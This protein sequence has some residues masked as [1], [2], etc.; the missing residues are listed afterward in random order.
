MSNFISTFATAMTKFDEGTEAFDAYAS[1]VPQVCGGTETDF[2]SAFEAFRQSALRTESLKVIEKDADSYKVPKSLISRLAKG[3]AYISEFTISEVKDDDGKVITPA[4]TPKLTYIIEYIPA[5]GEGDDA[6]PES[7][8]LR[9][10][11]GKVSTRSV[12][13]GE[14]KGR[15][16]AF[17]AWDKTGKAQG[18]TFVIIKTKGNDGKVD[19]YKV[20]GRFVGKGKLTQFLLKMHPNSKTVAH[21]RTYPELKLGE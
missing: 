21:M 9:V 1:L 19:G 10:I 12:G 5:T 6:K 17:V 8:K 14:K 13:K 11:A 20:D 18:D 15:I 16:S 2:R 4:F 7:A 3:H